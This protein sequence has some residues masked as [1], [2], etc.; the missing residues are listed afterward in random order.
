MLRHGETEW[1]L[2]DRYQGRLDSPLTAR[3][4]DQA[5]AMADLLAARLADATGL[6]L[7]SSP[8]GRANETAWIIGDRLGLPVRSDERL[9]E[10][11]LGSWDGLSRSEIRDRFSDLLRGASSYDWYFRAPDGETFDGATRRLKAWIG[12]LASPTIAVTHGLASRLLRGLYAGLDR[13]TA[14]A[15][16]VSQ[17]A[18]FRLADGA[19]AQVSPVG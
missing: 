10:V 6:A 4:R 15:L 9:R 5:R 3:G 11:S 1:N 19:I 18:L 14:L 2:A 12:G 8:Q 16:P 17:G 13:E 7:V